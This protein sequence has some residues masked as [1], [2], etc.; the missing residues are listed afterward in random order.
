M[1]T[2]AEPIAITDEGKR[3]LGDCARELDMVVEHHNQLAALYGRVSAA[4][5]AGD[6]IGAC[7]AC[8]ESAKVGQALVARTQIFNQQLTLME[9]VDNDAYHATRTRQLS[10][11]TAKKIAGWDSDR[12]RAAIGNHGQHCG[13]DDCPVESVMRSRLLEL[14]AH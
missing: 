6:Y 8:V 14:E 7:D 5:R 11:D 9:Q 4:L 1:N 10:R 13:E 2:E 12:L 3:H